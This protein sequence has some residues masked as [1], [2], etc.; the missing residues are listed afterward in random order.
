[1]FLETRWL[2][3]VIPFIY[4][5]YTPTQQNNTELTGD[6][7]RLQPWAYQS[8]RMTETMMREPMSMKHTKM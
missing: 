8:W 5:Q 6:L 2:R 1:M 3:V 4:I 7:L